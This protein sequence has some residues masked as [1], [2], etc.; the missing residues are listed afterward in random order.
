MLNRAPAALRPLLLL[1]SVAVLPGCFVF[2]DDGP[3]PN[4]APRIVASSTTWSCGWDEAAGDYA[5]EFQ[6]RVTD[7]DG[8]ADVFEVLVDVFPS[9]SGD[10]LESFALLD[11]GSGLWGGRILES[12][13]ALRCGD[14]Y[15]VRFEA[16]DSDGARDQFTLVPAPPRIDDE[17]TGWTCDFYP[18]RNDADGF[19]DVVDV[20]VTVYLADR[21]IELDSFFLNYEGN[22][23]WGG[24]IDESTSDLLCGDAIDV[25]YDAWDTA[26]LTDALLLPYF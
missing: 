24:I 9:G 15:D 2:V 19:D 16:S 17:S 4:A 18:E 5:F 3:D 26:G 13:S 10:A 1:A 14:A 6:T 21:D 23:V 8:A 11:E 22:G 25:L 7:A 12:D 20:L